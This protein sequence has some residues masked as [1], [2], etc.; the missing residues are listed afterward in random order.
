MALCLSHG[1]LISRS[2]GFK[3]NFLLIQLPLLHSKTCSS[4]ILMNP[5]CAGSNPWCISLIRD[6][7]MGLSGQ[8]DSCGLRKELALTSVHLGQTLCCHH[9]HYVIDRVLLSFLCAF[10]GFL[11]FIKEFLEIHTHK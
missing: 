4:Y 6:G 10:A 2:P 8:A 5:F 1:G 11:W 9:S 3:S 7:S